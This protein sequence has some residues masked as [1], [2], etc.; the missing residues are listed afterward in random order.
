M[1]L[2]GKLF[3]SQE[4]DL[5]FL[6]DDEKELREYE[7][8]QYRA[9]SGIANTVSEFV[10]T[11]IRSVPE[12]N[13]VVISGTVTSGTFST[14]DSIEIYGSSGKKAESTLLVIGQYGKQTDYV[15]EGA[16]AEFHIPNVQ[17]NLIKRNDIIKKL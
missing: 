3:N 17:K 9:E 13:G 6:T 8:N 1:G 7:E 14:G 5:D 16:N 10:A 11:E 2:L 12:I 15:S 4:R